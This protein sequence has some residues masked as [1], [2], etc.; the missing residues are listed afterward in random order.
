[1]KESTMHMIIIGILIL[2]IILLGYHAYTMYY[3]T[4]SIPTSS[5]SSIPKKEYYTSQPD[6]AALHA[7]ATTQLSS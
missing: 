3:S 4:K 5:S 6:N 2:S 1:M 7:Y